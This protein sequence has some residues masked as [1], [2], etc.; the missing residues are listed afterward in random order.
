MQYDL[1]LKDNENTK[2]QGT[3]DRE[4]RQDTQGFTQSQRTTRSDDKAEQV[5]AQC[6]RSAIV[7]PM[8]AHSS[9]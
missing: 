1:V 7:T 2:G 5:Q 8:T 3:Y 9:P 6:P 4:A